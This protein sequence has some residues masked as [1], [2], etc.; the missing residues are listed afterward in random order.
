MPQS[1]AP[2]RQAYVAPV[3][4]DL[5]LAATQAKPASAPEL[6]ASLTTS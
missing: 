6:G 4:E 3:V 2:V 1:Q 5:S